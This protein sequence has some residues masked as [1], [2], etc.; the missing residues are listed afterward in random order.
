[1]EPTALCGRLSL[2]HLPFLAISLAILLLF[3]EGNRG[4][5]WG[6]EG[7]RRPLSFHWH[8]GV[9]GDCSVTSPGRDI[10]SSSIL[11]PCAPQ[12]TPQILGFAGFLFLGSLDWFPTPP[13]HDSIVIPW[14][15]AP[16]LS[17]NEGAVAIPRGGQAHGAYA[18]GSHQRHSWRSW[19]QRLVN[20]NATILAPYLASGGV[21]S[22]NHA[23]ASTPPRSSRALARRARKDRRSSGG[24]FP[25]RAS[26]S[27]KKSSSN[28]A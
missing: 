12:P 14:S 17:M 23:R 26:R 28:R 11:V 25:P 7:H 19:P 5:W 9:S 1:M 27:W 6:M 2:R 21:H 16:S 10:H 8:D 15:W 3:L 13:S 20:L 18:P 22:S 24:R 4:A